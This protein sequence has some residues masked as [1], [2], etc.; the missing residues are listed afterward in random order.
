MYGFVRGLYGFCMGLYRVLIG[1]CTGL[2]RFVRAVRGVYGGVGAYGNICLNT[3]LF[4]LIRRPSQTFGLG[5]SHNPRP[6]RYCE[7]FS[8]IG[9]LYLDLGQQMCVP[10]QNHPTQP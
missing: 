8:A 5:N 3:G 10:L 1:T 7:H 9:P 2:Y 6:A 4:A